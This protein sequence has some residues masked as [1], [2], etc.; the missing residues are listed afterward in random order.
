[1]GTGKSARK[2]G[3]AA[4]KKRYK[5][6][7]STRRRA[8]DVDQIQDE[9]KEIEV[10]GFVPAKPL[11]DDLPGLGQYHCISCSRHFISDAVL[12]AHYKTKQHKRRLKA[13]M[14]MPYSQREAEAAAGMGAP[15]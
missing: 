1:M 15:A 6:A 11:D 13:V 5:K 10:K 9:I 4:K 8:K 12:T 3:I 7:C 2:K 14:D